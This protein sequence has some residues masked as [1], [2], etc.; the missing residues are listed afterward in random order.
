LAAGM[1]DHIT[2]PVDVNQMFTTLARW[3][4]PGHPGKNETAMQASGQRREGIPLPKIEGLDQEAG[5]V[6]VQGDKALYRRLL[7]KFRETQRRFV[8]AFRVAREDSEDDTALRLVHTLKGLA[9]TLGATGLQEAA[10][11]LEGA[12][13]KQAPEDQLAVRLQAVEG[14]LLPLISLLDTLEDTQ[15]S[16]PDQPGTDG[17]VPLLCE[18]KSLLQ[19][20]D[21]AAGDLLTPI[22]RRL[23]GHPG[24][25]TLDELIGDY[26]FEAATERLQEM[27]EEL[28]V[29][30][31]D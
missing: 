28:G 16:A 15:E 13:R 1:N 10:A 27:A 11:G 7:T 23:G 21:T 9:G 12:C 31:E 26:E 24:L 22:K 2:K 29:S 30:L 5:L 8:E 25:Q 17:L 14:E 19:D 18:L 20:N 4:S 3:I 6:R